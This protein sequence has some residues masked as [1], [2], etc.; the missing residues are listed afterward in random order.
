MLHRLYL[1]CVGQLLVNYS[2][3]ELLE[4]AGIF[5]NQ[6][7]DN[8]QIRTTV[9]LL[10]DAKKCGSHVALISAAIDPPVIAL[11]QKLEVGAVCSQLAYDNDGHV[12]GFGR[13]LFG[14]KIP[15]LHQY[16]DGLDQHGPVTV[17]SDNANDIEMLRKVDRGIIVQRRADSRI[18][19]APRVPTDGLEILYI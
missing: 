14:R 16:L 17:Y 2:R 8:R 4:Y 9:E 18:S 11:S 15:Y 5:W 10:A 6:C 7:W 13:D 19:E 1:R 3:E 12:T